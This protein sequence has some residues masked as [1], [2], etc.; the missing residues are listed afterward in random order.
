MYY[1]KLFNICGWSDDEISANS[2]RIEYMLEKIDCADEASLKHAENHVSTSFD[3]TIPG[4]SKLLRMYLHEFVDC[5]NIKK[6]H[7]HYVLLGQPLHTFFALTNGFAQQRIGVKTA[8]VKMSYMNAIMVLGMIFDKYMRVLEHGEQVGPPAG[9][10]HCGYFQAEAG[11][12]GLGILPIPDLA[13]SAGYF[14]DQAAECG[15]MLSERFG[16][17]I[18]YIDG[19]MDFTWGELPDKRNLIYAAKT[20]K[21]GFDKIEELTGISV[22][23]EDHAK[24]WAYMEKFAMLFLPLMGLIGKS[25]PQCMSQADAALVFQ[26]GAIAPN[27]ERLDS[28]LE[29]VKEIVEEAKRRVLEGFG[30]L[31]KGAPKVYVGMQTGCDVG[32][33]K[34]FEDAG[35]SVASVFVDGLAKLEMDSKLGTA[36]PICPDPDKY[37]RITEAR[38]KRPGFNSSLYQLHFQEKRMKELNCDGAV[39]S[40]PYNC[41]P[42]AIMP[43]AG[44]DYLEKQ[45]GKPV[46]VMETD[47]YDSRLI[48]PQQQKTRLEAF[49]EI[50]KLRKA[51]GQ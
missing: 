30:I 23:D 4:L 24:A 12:L 8:A 27:V 1:T 11:L 39:L 26:V 51:M 33:L 17:D 49:A 48:S 19:C 46:M 42:W 35:L 15:E 34:I 44:K 29:A 45:T 31:P 7:E 32:S 47:Y 14:C 5:V 6:E 10:A 21:K 38:Y 41:R 20:H 43:L 36:P 18:F 25:D 40:Y 3:L 50:L 9:A 16:Y 13:L 2:A 22:T 28:I 37:Q